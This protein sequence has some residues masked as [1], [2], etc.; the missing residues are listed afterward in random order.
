[1]AL[2]MLEKTSES[3]D[4]SAWPPAIAAEFERE[5]MNPFQK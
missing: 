3:A 5:R 1:M 2:T 4:L